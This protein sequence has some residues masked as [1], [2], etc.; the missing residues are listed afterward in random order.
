M[1]LSLLLLLLPCC[2]HAQ[3]PVITRANYFDIGDSA[4]VYYKFD[5][6]LW[7]VSVGPSGANVTW[8]YSDMDF[9]HPSVIVDTVFFISPVGT[10]F[11]TEYPQANIAMLRK[12]DPFSTENNDYNYYYVTND[13]LSFLG[14]WAS[15]GGTELWEDSFTNSLKELRFPLTYGDA[16]VDSFTRSFVDYSGSGT[17]YA[18]GTYTV[19]VDGYGMMVTPDGTTLNDV[20]RVHN[21][22][23]T[24]DSSML[25]VDVFTLHNYKW[26]SQSKKAFVLSMQTAFGDSMA[27]ETAEYQKQTNV[28]TSVNDQR[29]GGGRLSVYPNPTNDVATISIE[30]HAALQSI[31]LYNALGQ[32]IRF[33]KVDT[34]RNVVFDMSDL[35]NGLYTIRATM[36]DGGV[37]QRQVA[38]SR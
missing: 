35:P 12:T 33:L 29:L 2:L 24:K 21:K 18:T 26:Y 25:G 1:R 28:I 9:T 23:T 27:V 20:I 37:M 8:D 14:H 7:S 4:L 10:P 6:S 3:S 22:T 16:Y 17:H 13:S 31:E 19:T 11:E 32:R 36:S 30:H 15:N 38:V 34:K 5:T